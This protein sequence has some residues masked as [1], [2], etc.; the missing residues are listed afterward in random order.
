IQQTASVES[1][2]INTGADVR[3]WPPL[4]II[5][6]PPLQELTVQVFNQVHQA[7]MFPKSWQ[8]LKVR[9]LTKKGDF[10]S[11]RT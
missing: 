4:P 3:I 8:E 5:P 11:L 7:Q 1:K 6:L 2:V 10:T 9:F